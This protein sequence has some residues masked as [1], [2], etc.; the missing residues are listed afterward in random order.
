MRM[1]RYC[2]TRGVGRVLGRVVALGGLGVVGLVASAVQGQTPGGGGG[3]RGGQSVF[4]AIDPPAP[5]ALPGAGLLERWLLE[6]PWM[7]MAILVAAGAAGYWMLRRSED[8]RRTR[9]AGVALAVGSVLALVVYAVSAVVETD[10]EKIS[11]LTRDVV[12]A[13]A[14]GEI[15]RLDDLLNDDCILDAALPGLGMG[16][17]VSKQGIL[18]RVRAEFGPN[19]RN[20]TA[21]PVLLELQASTENPAFARTQIKLRVTSDAWNFPL[22]SWWRM[23]WRRQADGSWRATG[24]QLVS[25]PGMR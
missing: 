7:L 3:G 19:A 11:G 22:L 9:R 14:T 6:S 10:R 20:G 1:R 8:P 25:M 23:D 15:D 2:R 24:I 4:S 18:D 16:A 17:Q 13:T 21:R 12:R 5:P